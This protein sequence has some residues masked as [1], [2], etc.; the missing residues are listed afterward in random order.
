M[1]GFT[2]V[3]TCSGVV[4]GSDL[5]SIVLGRLHG[6]LVAELFELGSRALGA[7]GL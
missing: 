4:V 2:A 5:A 7:R 1:P 6:V 3:E